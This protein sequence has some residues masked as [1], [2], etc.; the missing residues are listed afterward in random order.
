MERRIVE[1]SLH[2]LRNVKNYNNNKFFSFTY[3]LFFKK[4]EIADIFIRNNPIKRAAKIE[5]RIKTIYKPTIK[6]DRT[7]TKDV[8]G[9]LA[10]KL[11]FPFKAI[12]ESRSQFRRFFARNHRRS[13]FTNGFGRTVRHFLVISIF[14]VP[15]SLSQRA[16]VL[17]AVR[18]MYFTVCVMQT[19]VSS[20]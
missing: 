8:L 15:F 18:Y 16:F 12:A 6:I 14:S 2:S 7:S 20:L 19:R 10:A 4:M 11:R 1:M 17:T 5:R 3:I 9:Q 13:V